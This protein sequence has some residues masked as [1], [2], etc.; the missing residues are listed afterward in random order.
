LSSSSLNK[1]SSLV[2]M[3]EERDDFAAVPCYED[4]DEDIQ[5]TARKM[6]LANGFTISNDTLALLCSRLSNDRK[7]SLGEL[8]KLITYMGDYRN[9]TS[10]DVCKV[11]SDNSA[12]SGD[13]VCYFTASGQTDKALK[14]YQKLLAEDGDPIMVVRGLTY[15]FL[16]L[17]NCA[18]QIEKG[19]TIDNVVNKSSPP[20]IFFRKASFKAQLSLWNKQRLL[21]A[22]E[23]LYKADRDCK[24]TNMP[25]EEI[26]SYLIMALSSATARLKREQYGR[27]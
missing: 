21:A 18:A 5:A 23:H 6:F 24:T 3:A 4:R 19:E 1:K 8:E 14:A 11:I 22:M 10:D 20:I 25:A 16:R 12:T 2:A 9:I 17:L 27:Y 26:V 15:H 7:S 13:D